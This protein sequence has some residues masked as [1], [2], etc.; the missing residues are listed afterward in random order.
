MSSAGKVRSNAESGG[1]GF[2]KSSTPELGDDDYWMTVPEGV[3]GE[4]LWVDVGCLIIRFSDLNTVTSSA[5]MQIIMDFRWNDKR[6]ANY[7]GRDLPDKL[8]GPSLKI[9][10]ARTAIPP[11]VHSWKMIDATIGRVAMTL[12]YD[13]VS[14]LYIY[15][16]ILFRGGVALPPAFAFRELLV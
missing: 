13:G 12:R 15:I 3:N 7:S 10:N 6:L 4:P 14:Y 16:Y 1:Y 8:W 2:D 5:K 9:G 11:E